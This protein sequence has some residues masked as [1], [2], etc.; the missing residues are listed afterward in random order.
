MCEVLSH[1]G[2]G[3]LLVVEYCYLDT[4]IQI[5]LVVQLTEKYLWLL[6]QYGISNDLFVQ[7]E[8]G[9][10]SSEYR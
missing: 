3:I 9:F 4:Q 6:L 8:A 1:M 7:Q 5:K 10:H 2:S